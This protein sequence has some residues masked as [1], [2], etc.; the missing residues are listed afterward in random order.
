MGAALTG[1]LGLHGAI[2]L[3]G[4][5]KWSRLKPVPQLSGRTLIPL[6]LQAQSLFAAGWMVALLLLLFAAVLRVGRQ[7]TWW[8][9]A[10]PGLLLSQGLITIAWPDAKA[11]TIANALILIAVVLAAGH[12]RFVQ[13]IDGEARTLLAGASAPR[14]GPVAPTELERLP[15]PVRRW[16]GESG[17]TT[18]P[19]IA[20]ARLRQ[21]GTLRMK[22]EGPW[23][24]IAAEQYFSVDPPAFVWRV[25]SKM[26]R[27]L[28]IAGRDRYAG[29]RGRMLIKAGSIVPIVD[30]ADAKIDQGAMLR[31]LGEIIW[32]PSAALGPSISWEPVDA[33]HARATLRDAG[34][35]VSAVFTFDGHGRVIRFDAQRY[36][37]GGDDA[38]LTPW[39]A[40]CTSWR[41]FEGIEVP[42]AG[43]VGW[44]LPA[45]PFIYFRWEILDLA[46]NRTDLVGDRSARAARQRPS[47]GAARAALRATSSPWRA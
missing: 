17:A 33:K 47:V 21:K 22:P 9:A 30:A 26:M 14:G 42:S 5:L 24:P 18:R 23:M 44:E 32:F 34:A 39:F 3:L 31:Y 6:S 35:S 8:W 7:A 37:G 10:L 13:R 28:P 1:L 25:D 46:F 19:R 40:S 20:T 4:F 15:A 2:H 43:E 38:K 11:G 27:V 45:G 41:R 36:L 12:A 29:G 16:M